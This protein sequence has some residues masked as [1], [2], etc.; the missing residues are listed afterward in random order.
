MTQSRIK[1]PNLFDQD[2]SDL[3]Q[4]ITQEKGHMCLLFNFSLTPAHSL[5]VADTHSIEIVATVLRHR[6][7]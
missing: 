4:G 1:D 5:Y 3:W 6:P 7:Y 2:T